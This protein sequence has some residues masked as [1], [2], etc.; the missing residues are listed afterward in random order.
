MVWAG[1]LSFYGGLLGALMAPQSVPLQPTQAYEE[2]LLA[3]LFAG[4]W[5]GRHCL[6]R[7]GESVLASAYLLG[8]GFGIAILA[9]AL[10]PAARRHGRAS[11][12]PSLRL[13]A[14]QS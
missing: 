13:E 5:L 11:S 12:T 3:A 7:L 1:G 6:E 4:P 9:V 8:L 2:I 10:F 14:S